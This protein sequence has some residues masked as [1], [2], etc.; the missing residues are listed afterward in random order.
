MPRRQHEE[1]SAAQ[2]ERWRPYLTALTMLVWALLAS[3][4]IHTR[5]VDGSQPR[6]TPS[7]DQPVH[8]RADPMTSCARNFVTHLKAG[9]TRVKW[10]DISLMRGTSFGEAGL[11]NPLLSLDVGGRMFAPWWKFSTGRHDACA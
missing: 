5:R 8:A 3:S 6:A 10:C 7:T 2:S 9:Q 4:Q 11:S 1:F